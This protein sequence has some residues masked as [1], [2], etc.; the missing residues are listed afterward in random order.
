[1][2]RDIRPAT[3]ADAA[4]IADMSRRLVEEG[5]P[6]SWNAPRVARHIGRRDN[7]VIKTVAESTMLGFAIMSFSDD[8]AHLNLLAVEPAYR[9][10]SIARDMVAWLEESA[11]CAGT[12]FISL[13]VRADNR[14]AIGFYRDMGYDETD[15]IAGYYSG[16]EDAIVFARDLRTCELAWPDAELPPYGQS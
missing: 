4:L 6:R 11:I 5:L 13:E 14:G 1:M 9:R 10:L 8:A 7:V 12:F 2:K 3:S 15:V 16:I